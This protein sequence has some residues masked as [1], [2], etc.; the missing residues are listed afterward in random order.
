MRRTFF[1]SSYGAVTREFH[2]L[3]LEPIILVHP[4]TEYLQTRKDIICL[5]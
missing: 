5:P 4:A 2:I 3:I 1:R